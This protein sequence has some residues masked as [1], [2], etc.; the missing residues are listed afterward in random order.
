M[1]AP[2]LRTLLATNA[3]VAEAAAVEEAGRGFELFGDGASVLR[4]L[5]VGIEGVAT[6]HLL[7]LTVHHVA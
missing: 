2:L 4:C 7:L 1:P 6:H 5:L 3:A